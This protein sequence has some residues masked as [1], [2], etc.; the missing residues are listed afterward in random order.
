MTVCR[1]IKTLYHFDPPASEDEVRAA[2][3]QFV[4]KV[5]GF[6]RPS[7]ANQAAFA[8]AVDAVAA[9]TAVLLGALETGAPHRHRAAQAG[10]APAL[11]PPQAGSTIKLEKTRWQK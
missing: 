6:N 9:A 2:A 11:P 5:S 8:A 7:Q 10:R 1:N 4:R 3:L